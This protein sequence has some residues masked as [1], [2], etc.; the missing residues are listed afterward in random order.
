MTREE[1]RPMVEEAKKKLEA[2]EAEFAESVRRDLE[3][4]KKKAL[5]GL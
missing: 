3:S 5:D 4:F 1:I 2:A